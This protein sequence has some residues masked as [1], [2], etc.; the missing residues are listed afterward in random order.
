M[1]ASKNG[2]GWIYGGK[3]ESDL[4]RM[5]RNL[6][7]VLGNQ[8]LKRLHVPPMTNGWNTGMKRLRQPITITQ[9]QGRRLGFIRLKA[10]VICVKIVYDK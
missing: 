3:I 8:L 2:I 1:T 5:M 10:A 4:V 6:V 9:L 7:P